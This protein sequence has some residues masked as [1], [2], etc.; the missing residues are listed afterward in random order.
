M[1]NSGSR[2]IETCH[3]YTWYTLTQHTNTDTNLNLESKL[4]I[5]RCSTVSLCESVY[6]LL[7]VCMCV[8]VHACV[9][10]SL[11]VCACMRVCVQGPPANHNSVLSRT[12]RQFSLR[13]RADEERM[14]TCV[15]RE[16]IRVCVCVCVC[17]CHCVS[18]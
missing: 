10:G 14:S 5:S 13:E 6:L 12:N 15:R 9:L 11:N 7:N 1:K 8:L 2:W 16:V 18:I 4:V 17:V 3:P